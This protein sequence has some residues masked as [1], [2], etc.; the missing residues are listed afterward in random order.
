MAIM[1]VMNLENRIQTLQTVPVKMT[2]IALPDD[3]SGTWTNPLSPLSD[4]LN[5]ALELLT[6]RAISWQSVISNFK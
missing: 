4:P 6:S 1:W 3:F 5:G 2:G